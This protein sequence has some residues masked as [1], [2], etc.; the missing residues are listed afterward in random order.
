MHRITPPLRRTV[1]W[2]WVPVLGWVVANFFLVNC[3]ANRYAVAEPLRRGLPLGKSPVQRATPSLR[4]TVRWTWVAVLAWVVASFF[5]I[6]YL[7]PRTLSASQSVHIAQP[8]FWSALA[9]VAFLCW[10]RLETR[11]AL[12]PLLVFVAGLAG[13]FHVALLVLAGVMLGFGHS[14][15]AHTP[16]MTFLNV[17]YVGT[18]LVGMEFARAYLLAVFARRGTFLV[19]AAVSLLFTLVVIPVAR[20]TDLATTSSAFEASGEIFLPGLSQNLLASFLA[21]LGG[22]LASIAY[23]GVLEAYEWLSPILPDLEWTVTAFVGTL[24]PAAALLIVRGLYL[25]DEEEAQQ[26][27][28]SRRAASPTGWVMVGVATVAIIWFQTGLLGVQPHLISG[29]SM[30]PTLRMGDIAITRNVSPEDVEVGDIIWYR[31]GDGGTSI[32]HRVIEVEPAAGR[33]VFVTRGDANNTPDEP[34]IAE[35]IEG[36]VVLTIPKIGWLPITLKKFIN[37]WT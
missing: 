14:P 7:F 12:S 25:Q 30:E 18:A 3:L 1:R 9:V 4:G 8:L 36:E 35:Q 27:A 13:V 22:P 23:L 33:P 5:L 21:L 17:V 16:Y 10:R 2:A 11:P 15:Y 32:M 31:H 37:R 6:N 24:A 29:V 26:P 20:F 19:L 34:I 28:R